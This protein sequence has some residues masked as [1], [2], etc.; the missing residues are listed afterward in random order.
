MYALYYTLPE[1][2]AVLS[3]T[4]GEFLKI[5]SIITIVTHISYMCLLFIVQKMAILNYFVRGHPSFHST[6]ST[7]FPGPHPFPE[8]IFYQW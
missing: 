6:K 4:C 5:V 1:Q 8:I 7:T 2:I 3:E